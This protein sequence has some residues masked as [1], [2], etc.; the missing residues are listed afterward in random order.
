MDNKEQWIKWNSIAD[1][2]NSYYIESIKDDINGLRI[3]LVDEKN[4][5]NRLEVIFE[6]FEAYRNID[7]SY[8]TVLFK[9]L[10]KNKNC[11]NW[12]FFKVENSTYLKW[13][14]MQSDGWIDYIKRYHYMFVTLD[15]VLD[16]VSSH[17]PK[18][19]FY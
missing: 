10:Y 16:V 15:S 2:A 6:N 9:D 7:E 4:N 3:F 13:L 17:D 14:S 1:L 12:T 18:L 8:R 19:R 5:K 11:A